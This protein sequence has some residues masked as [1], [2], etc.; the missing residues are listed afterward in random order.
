MSGKGK[1]KFEH[2]N[3]ALLI[4]AKGK[5]NRPESK[6]QEFTETSAFTPVISEPGY[7]GPMLIS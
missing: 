7:L 3:K 2:I 4:I 1:S 6:K 5:T